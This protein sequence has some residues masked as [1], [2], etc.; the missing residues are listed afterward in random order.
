MLHP[1][2][3]AILDEMNAAPGPPAHEVPIAEARAAHAAESE[4][5]SGPGEP[6]A[7]VRDVRVPAAGGDVLVRD[8]APTGWSIP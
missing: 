5:W 7:E 2:I 6:V 3:Q 1:E 8:P 4:R